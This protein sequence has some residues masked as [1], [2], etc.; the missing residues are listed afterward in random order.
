MTV[1]RYIPHVRDASTVVIKFEF[2][3]EFALNY[4]LPRDKNNKPLSR[5]FK[6]SIDSNGNV[7]SREDDIRCNEDRFYNDTNLYST[8]IDIMSEQIKKDV[9]TVNNVVSLIP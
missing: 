6:Y 5:V 7:V 2:K 3:H 4:L 1:N 9:T 8:L